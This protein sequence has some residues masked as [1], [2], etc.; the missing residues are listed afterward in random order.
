MPNAQHCERAFTPQDVPK[1]FL[2]PRGKA[3]YIPS[4]VASPKSSLWAGSH[5]EFADGGIAVPPSAVDPTPQGRE[6]EMPGLLSRSPSQGTAGWHL[7][8][9]LE[10]YSHSPQ[11][12]TKAGTVLGVLSAPRSAPV[13]CWWPAAA[14][15]S[16]KPVFLRA[17][18]TLLGEPCCR[19]WG[20][21]RSPGDKARTE[22]TWR[23]EAPQHPLVPLWDFV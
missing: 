18:W 19:A 10:G 16:P 9:C 17:A 14:A 7:L 2:L 13:L 5:R 23:G 20:L 1:T 8:S 4:P 6:Q 22:S 3:L 21:V 11:N 12:S 15:A